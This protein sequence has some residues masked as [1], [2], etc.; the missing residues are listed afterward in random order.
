MLL[1]TRDSCLGFPLL[2]ERPLEGLHFI[3]STSWLK[4]K[5]TSSVTALFLLK[6]N[7]VLL[8]V[9]VEGFHN[10]IPC[11]IFQRSKSLFLRK[12]SKEGL[13]VDVHILAS[14]PRISH[15]RQHSP[16]SI[17]CYFSEYLQWGLAPSSWRKRSSGIGSA[18]HLRDLLE[19]VYFR[20]YIIFSYL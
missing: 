9:A 5:A 18:Y 13:S 10:T 2:I 17:L 15:H 16:F 12:V 3:F 20:F 1:S 19:E 11:L 8:G 14:R 4:A 7:V 6:Y